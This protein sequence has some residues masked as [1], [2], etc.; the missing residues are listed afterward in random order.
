MRRHLA[1][2]PAIALALGLA[3][4]GPGDLATAPTPEGVVE[5]GTLVVSMARPASL[6]PADVVDRSG[7]A[8]VRAMCDPLLDVDRETGELVP[9]VAESWIVTDGGSR[10]VVRLRDGLRFP[11][12]TAVTARD[13]VFALSRAASA[14]FAGERADLLSGIRGYA[15][16]RGREE[17]EVPRHRREFAGL[18]VTSPLAFE[19]SL[20]AGAPA[21]L[22][23][24]T[25]P[26][27]S[28][29]SRAAAEADPDGFAAAPMC[30]G[31]YRPVE[32]FD[33]EGRSFALE[34]VAGYPGADEAYPG[35]GRGWLDRL[36][37]R[38]TGTADE[39]TSPG[40]PRVATPAH[41]EHDV[42]ELTADRLSAARA[43]EDVTLLAVPGPWLQYV[44][45]PASVGGPEV[46]RALS[47]ALDR[48]RL[49]EVALRGTAAP[50]LGFLP[51][52]VGDRLHDPA[53]CGPDRVPARADVE[54][55]RDVLE[56]A[57]LDLRGQTLDV[58]TNPDFAN[59][60][61]M[62]E[63]ARQWRAAFDG[64]GA[65]FRQVPWDEFV[66]RF[67]DP[68]GFATAFRTSHHV[69]HPS[70]DAWFAPFRTASIGSL[71]AVAFSDPDVDR[72][73]L[74]EAPRAVEPRDLAVVHREVH[75][76]LCDQLPLIPLVGELRHHALG[77]SVASATG[78][79]A[80]LADPVT[81][82][83]R[84][85]LLSARTP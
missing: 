34:R 56:A 15:I 13:A 46:R 54:A 20:E 49:A 36:E 11:D 18:R 30:V 27:S 50:A 81:G 4:C 73:L 53:G 45:V 82:G 10:V 64:F 74:E 69:P 14:E 68:A 31:P 67:E 24:L 55:A 44:G 23:V 57:G 32:P 59:V 47:L 63:V 26:V 41:G 22:P 19:M 33:P 48:T 6:D 70:A 2:L 35:R 42:V 76:L 39:S 62:A 52:A 58:V 78:D 83:L 60:P 72:L 3:A 65:R 80:D 1:L 71:N 85:R 25:H 75:E 17:A 29:L 37:F 43:D 77:P 79:L 51:P 16:L 7:E 40:A 8:V 28:P 38:W 9:A 84:L 12:G 21:V 61:L 66:L 5:G